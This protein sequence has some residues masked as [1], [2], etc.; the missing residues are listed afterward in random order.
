MRGL[1]VTFLIAIAILLQGCGKVVV[2]QNNAGN[3][4]GGGTGGQHLYEGNCDLLGA[5]YGGGNGTST[6]PY[7]VCTVTHL[8]NISQPGAGGHNYVL[9]KDLDLDGAPLFAIS[10]FTG[11]FDGN[12]YILNKLRDAMLFS[13][14]S[15]TIRNVILT[16][17]DI[18]GSFQT[19]VLL[20]WNQ[21]GGVV[22]NCHVSGL[23]TVAFGSGGLVGRNEGTITRSS[24]NV[25]IQGVDTL[26]GLVGLNRGTIN[27][28]FSQGSVVASSTVFGAVGGFVGDN[29]S[30]T[31]TDCYSS[32]S[33]QGRSRVGGF[34][35]Q[36]EA[37]IVNAYSTGAV[38]ATGA[39]LGGFG[40]LNTGT[41]TSGYFNSQT[42]G[43]GTTSG[44]T[45]KTTAEMQNSGTYVGFD[46]STIWNLTSY[47]VLR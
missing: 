46:F 30:G 27:K 20:G 25:A 33:A 38:A 40:G 32:A 43:I 45:A 17:A 16:N 26:G 39:D 3:G 44:G 2:P 47:P 13:N 34:F 4:G 36:N 6:D 35:G 8:Y 41:V 15:G 28:S 10:D 42:S 5:P 23:L 29:F 19:G 31:I 21:A 1:V 22:S 18:N 9:L 14:S 7:M 11:T 24:A 12:G 37:T